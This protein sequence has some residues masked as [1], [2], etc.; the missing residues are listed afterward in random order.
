MDIVGKIKRIGNIEAKTNNFCNRKVVLEYKEKSSTITQIVEFELK[1][2][3]VESVDGFFEGDLVKIHFNIRGR[4]YTKKDGSIMVF[5]SLDVY[6][7]EPVED[8]AKSRG[9]KRYEKN[10]KYNVELPF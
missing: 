1:N 8:P 4:E 2:G 9:V 5:N 3:H 7:I 6:K 10:E